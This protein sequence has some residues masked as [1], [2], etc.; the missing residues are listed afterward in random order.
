LLQ[1]YGII[2]LAWAEN[3]Y[4]IDHT[5]YFQCLHGEL[6]GNDLKMGANISEIENLQHH[7]IDYS[8]GKPYFV[9]GTY[10]MVIYCF[11][12]PLEFLRTFI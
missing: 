9:R 4:G 1:A 11:L 6:E 3:R 7:C 12:L 10:L 5:E 2:S 8:G